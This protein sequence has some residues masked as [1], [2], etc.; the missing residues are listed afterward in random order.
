MTTTGMTGTNRG[1]LETIDG[2]LIEVRKT[3]DGTTIIFVENLLKPHRVTLFPTTSQGPTR[4]TKDLTPCLHESPRTTHT[5]PHRMTVE[6]SAT[7]HRLPVSNVTNQ[8]TMLP[9]A[10]P[11]TTV[12]H[13]P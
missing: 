7:R 9:N 1:I 6:I 13:R 11:Q 8:A 2:T 3:I 5:L 10:Q 4:P 12:R